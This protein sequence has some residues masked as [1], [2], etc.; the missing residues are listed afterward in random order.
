MDIVHIRRS[1]RAEFNLFLVTLL[2]R[3]MNVISVNT[4]MW[5]IYLYIMNYCTVFQ[6]TYSIGPVVDLHHALLSFTV[7]VTLGFR[8]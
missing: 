4:I 1:I 7:K 6:F 3:N 8:V 5:L 2:N